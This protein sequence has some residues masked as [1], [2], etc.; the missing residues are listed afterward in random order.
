MIN[1]FLTT[2]TGR[3]LSSPLAI[4]S[5]V[6]LGLWVA[7][8]IA[9]RN[10]FIFHDAWQ[11]IFPISY[12]AARHSNCGSLATWMST[13]DSGSP[14]VL[15]VISFSM[16]QILRL[17]FLHLMGCFS[18]DIIPSLFIQKI[19]IFLTYLAFSGGMYVL[20]RVLFQRH[21]SAVY[22]FAATLYAGFCMNALHSDQIISLIFWLPWAVSCAVLFHRNRYNSKGAWYLNGAVFF[23][24]LAVLD[25]YPHI[26]LL[27]ASIGIG[28]YIL[29]FRKDCLLFAKY[30][31]FKLWPAVVAI[32]V[33]GVQLWIIQDTVADYIPSQRPSLAIDPKAFSTSNFAQ[34]TAL[35]S[36][37]LPLGMLVGTEALEKGFTNWMPALSWLAFNYKLDTLLFNLGFIPV[38]FAL[39]FVI[40]PEY[41]KL[42]IFWTGFALAT[43]F[44]ASQQ[45]N[46]YRLLFYLPTLNLFR[47]YYH[48]IN[49]SVFAV[50]VMSG[51]GMDAFLTL[52]LN[53]RKRM[54]MRSLMIAG[55]LAF[56][57]IV[58]VF[59]MLSYSHSL[60]M[61]LKQIYRY[62]TVDILFILL[63]M[64]ILWLC[65]HSLKPHVCGMVIIAIF[66][67]TKM[68]DFVGTY[69]LVGTSIDKVISRFNLD[70]D[71]LTPM[72]EAV[73]TSPDLFRR[74]ECT[75]F[76]QCYLSS[77][78]TVSLQPVG[79]LQGTFFRS[80]EEAIYQSG[81]AESA[82]KALSGITHPVFWLSEQVA[83]YSDKQELVTR[84]N[85]NRDHINQYLSSVVHV[86]KNDLSIIGSVDQLGAGRAELTYLERDKDVI[87]LS[88]QTEKQVFLN[89]AITYN[90]HWTAMVNDVPVSL[91]RG[92]F[93]GLA[94]R[95]PPGAGTVEIR[96]NSWKDDFLFNSRYLSMFAALFIIG[97]VIKAIPPRKDKDV[98]D[99]NIQK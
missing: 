27:I 2:K 71:D 28:M 37:F 74:K 8:H 4:L 80:K 69:E 21:L 96:Y 53:E 67:V 38:V 32:G 72:P 52:G 93:N 10:T 65:S 60:P 82:V 84:L 94:L 54:L 47:A 22:L 64:V 97:I 14:F 24:S 99:N 56:V 86:H 45:S 59:L 7:V 79:H 58:F 73:A 17:P 98:E 89:A 88:Y 76:A 35:I 3:W 40:R 31:A 51:Y 68:V 19:Q 6:L 41:K 77:R 66:T 90:A 1:F 20:G 34:P 46:L 55:G 81:L 29:L 42:R 87:R 43:F 33:L 44:L 57:A 92:N 63:G 25:E 5:I 49:F 15:Y 50:L 13:V 26:L 91:V 9:F 61:P 36:S 78:D 83:P 16:T 12:S 30:N 85:A 75:V 11:H 48:F 39:A 95:L 70:K 18:P 23:Y 62:L